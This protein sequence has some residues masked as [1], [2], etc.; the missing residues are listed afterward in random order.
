MCVEA[1]ESVVW[2][3]SFGRGLRE[4]AWGHSAM[5]GP[6]SPGASG[7]RLAQGPENA[8]GRPGELPALAAGG[9][10]S[11]YSAGRERLG[12]G[13]WDGPSHPLPPGASSSPRFLQLSPPAWP[14]TSPQLLLPAWGCLHICAGLAGI[15]I[16]WVNPSF[17]S[18]KL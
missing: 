8:R 14:L 6:A 1:M 3:C 16:L 10:G 9:P 15:S 18:N 17:K 2:L 13:L 7:R 11:E 12:C 5:G 4:R